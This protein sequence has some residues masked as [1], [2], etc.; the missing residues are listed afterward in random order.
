MVKYKVLSLITIAILLISCAPSK[1]VLTDLNFETALGKLNFRDRY[2]KLITAKGSITIDS[3]EF[4]SSASLRVNLKRPDTL[5]L[6]FET[7]FGINLGEVKI[8][9][10]SFELVDRF[11]DRTLSGRVSE[12]LRRYFEFN[13]KFDEIV[14]ILIAS[15]RVSNAE[16]YN[17][18][19]YGFSIYE[20]RGDEEITLNFNSDL[21][22]ESCT[23]SKGGDKFFEV[24][25]SRY[26]K[27][28]EIT[29]PKVIRIYDR[30][31]RGDLS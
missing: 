25:Y 20:R 1:K 10:D 31:G 18:A 19:D 12:Y 8:Y 6:K 15:P 3:P 30:H 21:E 13:L 22:L 17:L 29:L 2:V 27:V 9:G 11:N 16:M 5:M 26:V 24:R 28:G 14:D 23:L 4:S 7:V